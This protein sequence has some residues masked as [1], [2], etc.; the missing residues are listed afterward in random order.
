MATLSGFPTDEPKEEIRIEIK[1]IKPRSEEGDAHRVPWAKEPIKKRPKNTQPITENFCFYPK[2]LSKLVEYVEEVKWDSASQSMSVLI[3][4]T[5]QFEVY[6]WVSK[7]NDLLSAQQET[8]MVD[9]EDDIDNTMAFLVFLD[10]QKQEVARIKF[11]GIGLLQHEC[12][13]TKHNPLAK[14]D[15][16]DL[17]QHVA[18]SVVLSYLQSELLLPE[19]DWEEELYE[20]DSLKMKSRDDLLDEEW[21]TVEVT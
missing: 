7:I 12:V 15:V 17:G 11:K 1:E 9:W 14:Y 13:V 10:E 6:Q 16:S 3:V 19:I 4:E 8:P 2:I 5:P 20:G 18:H 21:K